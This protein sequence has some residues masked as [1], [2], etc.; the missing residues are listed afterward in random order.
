MSLVNNAI[1]RCHCDRERSVAGSNLS[2]LLEIAA[3]RHAS[4][5]ASALLAM[6]ILVIIHQTPKKQ[7]DNRHKIR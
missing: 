5:A 4:L 7:Y 6:T 1:F 3:S 2:E